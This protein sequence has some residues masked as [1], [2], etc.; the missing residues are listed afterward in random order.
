M[1]DQDDVKDVMQLAK[2]IA[3]TKAVNKKLDECKRKNGPRLLRCTFQ[4]DYT[5]NQ[6]SAYIPDVPGCRLVKDV[7]FK[8]NWQCYYP[9]DVAPFSCSRSWNMT[10]SSSACLIEVIAWAWDA[11]GEPCPWDLQTML[12]K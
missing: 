4:V 2:E 9:K 5:V 7:T 12:T 11:H 10:R 3:V 1:L 8:Q 6:A